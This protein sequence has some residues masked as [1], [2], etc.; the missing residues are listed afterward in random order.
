[1][2]IPIRTLQRHLA[3]RGL[4]FRNLLD[5]TRKE[6][7]REYLVEKKLSLV[8]TSFLLGYSEQSAF[9]RAFKRWHGI[10]PKRFQEQHLASN[11]SG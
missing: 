4:S 3:R 10:S 9:T 8:D 6:L 11:G 2:D 1:M 7:S 5:N